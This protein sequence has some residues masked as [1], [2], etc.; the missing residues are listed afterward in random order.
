MGRELSQRLPPPDLRVTR[1][2]LK[3]INAYL[4]EELG[5]RG[6]NAGEAAS[7]DA[8]CLDQVMRRRMGLPI[9]LSLVYLELA[10]RVG[11][12]M[13]GVNLPAHFMI[14]PVVEGSELLVD[15]FRMGELI[16]VETAEERL[17]ALYGK[18][19]ACVRRRSAADFGSH[20][21]AVLANNCGE[22][23]GL[24]GRCAGAASCAPML[25]GG[26]G[27][28]RQGV[29][30][31]QRPEAPDVPHARP[32]KPEAGALGLS[33]VERFSSSFPSGG[34]AQR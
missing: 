34:G 27:E 2:M 20:A 15:P 9:M 8:S 21:C 31:G 5:F 26:Q 19:S 22:R 28:D 4:F 10:R 3:A 16:D 18:V 11:F 6:A 1:R 29:L 13:I 32:H 12:E 7:P 33:T 25:T 30:R 17:A 14:R 23:P 24:R